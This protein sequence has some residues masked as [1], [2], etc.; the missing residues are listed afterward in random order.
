MESLIS[1]L[2]SLLFITH[3]AFA[4]AIDGEVIDSNTVSSL[5]GVS[6]RLL[7]D[8]TQLQVTTTD[9]NGEFSFGALSAGSYELEFEHPDY[10]GSSQTVSVSGDATVN[11]SASLDPKIVE[12]TVDGMRING[13]EWDGTP[14]E[15]ANGEEIQVEYTVVNTGNVNIASV[16][17]ARSEEVALSPNP[18]D[19]S[20]ISLG[21]GEIG[22]FTYVATIEDGYINSARSIQHRIFVRDPDRASGHGDPEDY[23]TDYLSP[24]SLTEDTFEITSSHRS[25]VITLVDF[26]QLMYEPG[27][28][29]NLT[30]RFRNNGEVETN[31]S[32]SV[33]LSDYPTSEGEI[34]GTSVYEQSQENIVLAPDQEKTLDQIQ[35][36]IPNDV[37]GGLYAY[38]VIKSSDG[39][40][41]LVAVDKSIARSHVASL[42]AAVKST[43]EYYRPVNGVVETLPMDVDGETLYAT[44]YY[45]I[46]SADVYSDGV[47][48]WA[49]GYGEI[50]YLIITDSQGAPIREESDRLQK[51]WFT[52]IGYESHEGASVYWQEVMRQLK[53]LDTH[54]KE[55]LIWYEDFAKGE[56][57]RWEM[58]SNLATVGQLFSALG[59]GLILDGTSLAKVNT[60]IDLLK[61]AEPTLS[62]L[63][64]EIAAYLGASSTQVQTALENGVTSNIDLTQGYQVPSPPGSTDAKVATGVL[65][66]AYVAF[67]VADPVFSYFKGQ[68]EANLEELRVD[69]T[70]VLP[71]MRRAGG[72]FTENSGANALS[73]GLAI[74][75]AATELIRN[76]PSYAN[77]VDALG[78]GIDDPFGTV[79]GDASTTF[80]QYYIMG[81]T[82]LLAHAEGLNQVDQTQPFADYEALATQYLESVQDQR[83][84]Q[85][86]IKG[87]IYY[88]SQGL[89]R[90]G[91]EKMGQM[92][93]HTFYADGLSAQVILPNDITTS[94]FTARVNFLD[95]ANAVTDGTVTWRI[96]DTPLSGVM[97]HSGDGQYEAS[98]DISSIAGVA[99]P[100][101]FRFEITGETRGKTIDGIR[102]FTVLPT[103][104]VMYVVVDPGDMNAAEQG[105]E[106]VLNANYGVET[107][108]IDEFRLATPLPDP[109]L[110]PTVVLHATG[111][112]HA[113]YEDPVFLQQLEDYLQAGG[114]V[115]LFGTAPEVLDLAGIT[116]EV[117]SAS[118]TYNTVVV[119]T[120]DHPVTEEYSFRQILRTGSMLGSKFVADPA[121]GIVELGSNGLSGGDPLLGELAYGNGKAIFLG[122]AD[123]AGATD[124][125]RSLTT[126]I[127][128]HL[129]NQGKTS[130]RVEMADTSPETQ[131]EVFEMVIDVT[132][133]GGVDPLAD[134]N[135][136]LS[137]PSDMAIDYV[138]VG[139]TPVETDPVVSLAQVQKG[140]T[141]QVV[142]GIRSPTLG[143]KTYTARTETVQN[144]FAYDRVRKVIHRPGALAADVLVVDLATG[145]SAA[146]EAELLGL[147]YGVA[148]KTAQEVIDEGVESSTYRQVLIVTHGSDLPAELKLSAF[149]NR[150]TDY[151]QAGGNVALFG[152][153]PEV[154]DLAGITDEVFSASRT[155]NTVVVRT[156][157]HPVTEEYSFRQILRT[158]SML[159]SKF[160]A[161]PAQGIVELGSNGLSGGD[162]LLGELAYGNGKAIFLG[163][164]DFAGATDDLRSLTTRIVDYLQLEVIAT[165]LV[166]SESTIEAGEN[167]NATLE[168]VDP[169]GQPVTGATV[170]G[171]V[172][173][174][175]FDTYPVTLSE[176]STPGTY[177]GTF[178]T[179]ESMPGGSYRWVVS[180]QAPNNQT[181]QAYVDFDVQSVLRTYDL[182]ISSNLSPNPVPPG[183]SFTV[184][185]LVSVLATGTPV[186][187]NLEVTLVDADDSVQDTG[188]T[189]A[190]SDGTYTIE[191]T[192]P[193]AYGTYYLNFEASYNSQAGASSTSF[194]VEQPIPVELSELQA[195]THERGVR[196]TWETV[197]ETG[198]AGF[199]IQR[200]INASESYENIGFVE[201]KGT[202]TERQTYSFVDESLPFNTT[203]T[204]YRLKQIDFDGSFEFSPEVEMRVDVPKQAVLHG[205]FPNPFSNRTTIRYE[206]PKPGRLLLEIYNAIGQRVATVADRNVAAGRKE[207]V[208]DAGA[209]ASGVYLLRF[210]AADQVITRKIVVVR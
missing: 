40:R 108:S 109:E 168:L 149:H 129:Q 171:Y 6:V 147:D 180:I 56:I 82:E 189:T 12:I 170:S 97:S 48:A 144:Y 130:L 95:G 50:E 102:Y 181:G 79:G 32:A 199:E 141:V 115:A 9:Q 76:R 60:K 140:E 191:L 5:D 207:I 51:A 85:D 159:G 91:I 186:P 37:S 31:Y 162:P 59:Q 104:G 17:Q 203:T 172:R 113:M 121:Q 116:D 96:P 188:T 148:T 106:D 133:Y 185:G 69:S 65:V 205:N 84:R 62:F 124:D 123:F 142:Y 33:L 209:L 119:R 120:T 43:A 150:L 29:V 145:Q 8:Q 128:D 89:G 127:V 98:I 204:T 83:S 41:E 18:V 146:L 208:Y 163:P 44:L 156:T 27:D 22:T 177:A 100:A 45:D 46:N 38:V 15:V 36:T 80:F 158:G 110:T 174:S 78:W 112:L 137:G 155:Y 184:S 19:V 210:Q 117:F 161:D 195:V 64:G 103:Q 3:F 111:S 58:Q 49:G 201:G 118:R 13:G 153:A 194:N 198:N 35:W 93:S 39:V 182:I 192:S 73:A 20:E 131:G 53:M 52:A 94:T 24:R 187:A 42:P 135:L 196:I 101:R 34:D 7:Q 75:G 105:L 1:T 152:T 47:N 183:E 90:L 2:L 202:T 122:P 160:V 165:D 26:D 126:R 138:A 72:Y 25:A 68:A 190:D 81:V 114:N 63:A 16:L 178:A 71:P 4:G 193:N 23:P 54:R 21:V 125:L 92:D 28:E 173:N 197:S 166:L 176:T 157:D 139:G 164:A 66:A 175:E 74:Q 86:L 134:V 57:S 132:G 87:H 151:L 30:V 11:V 14:Y 99:S 61:A 67:K 143:V 70:L 179:Q 10:L 206:V 169:D 107:V 136:T 200:M 55:T 154:L 77:V 167:A 88:D